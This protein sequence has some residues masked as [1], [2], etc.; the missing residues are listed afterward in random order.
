[1]TTNEDF[2]RQASLSAMHGLINL[3][4]MPEDAEQR[5]TAVSSRVDLLAKIRRM[6]EGITKKSHNRAGADVTRSLA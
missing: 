5:F 2:I 4:L 6:I 3:R 1:M